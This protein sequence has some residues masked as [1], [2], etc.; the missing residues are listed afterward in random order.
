LIGNLPSARHEE[1]MTKVFCNEASNRIALNLGALKNPTQLS[2]FKSMAEI[3]RN[4][5]EAEG[6]LQGNPLGI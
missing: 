2:N 4:V 1:L 5:C 3:S 6:V